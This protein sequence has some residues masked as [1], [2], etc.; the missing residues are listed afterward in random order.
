MLLAGIDIGTNTLRLL[1][2]GLEGHGL[3][4]VRIER[5]IT[6]LGEGI[7]RGG[8][9]L[10]NAMERTIK[11]LREF[12]DITH[13]YSVQEVTA[14]GTSAVRSARNRSHFLQRVQDE[15]GLMVEVISG[16]EE[17]QRT[18]MGTASGLKKEE[19]NFLILDIGGGSTEFI[20]GVG[21]RL[22]HVHSAPLGGVSLTEAFLLSD[23]TRSEEVERLSEAVR[24]GLQRVPL[25]Q[26]QEKPIRLIGTAGTVTTLA[27]MVLGLDRFD[28]SKVHNSLLTRPSIEK[29][30]SLLLDR[31]LAERRKLPGLE[32]GREDVIV[33]GVVIL[34]RVMELLRVTEVEVSDYGLLEGIVIH[35]AR[36]LGLIPI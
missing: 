36:R 30:L 21:G 24:V 23:P 17:A 18:F 31:T 27:A 1:I 7:G 22:D 15:T 25:F 12:C 6:R 29:I 13:L 28:R 19:G 14:V 35:H 8:N 2:A 5:R 26:D 34:L 10:P 33:A 3:R 11:A 4:E 9:L 32:A 16:E 20:L